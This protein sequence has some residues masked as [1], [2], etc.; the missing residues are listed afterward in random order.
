VDQGVFVDIAIGGTEGTDLGGAYVLPGFIDS[1]IHGFGPFDFE[2]P[3]CDYAAAAGALRHLGVTA[4]LPTVC[5]KEN[6]SYPLVNREAVL[7]FHLEGPFINPERLGGF[8]REQI[9][10]YSHSLAE[11]IFAS[12]HGQA[13]IMTAAPEMVSLPEMQALAESL[14]VRL[15][16]GHTQTDL[17]TARAAF[18][19]GFQAVTHFFNAM[20][21]HHHRSPGIWDEAML[22]DQVTLEVIADLHHVSAESLALLI[23]CKGARKL[24][25]V[26]DC[27]CA[28]G[29]GF[30]IKDG[31][32]YKNGVIYGSQSTMYDL[33][34]NLVSRLEVPLPLAVSMTSANIAKALGLPL[35]DIRRGYRADFLVMDEELHLKAIHTGMKMEYCL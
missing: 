2:D 8:S 15:S 34:V 23:R 25:A 1:H 31:L 22:N 13:R 12:F 4:F 5:P 30:E 21:G 29:S 10:P 20:P 9:L 28:N 3:G 26:T 17:I 24:I 7:G 33:F 11:E 16:A 32:A 6:S 19:G 14:H 35:G 27:V 18:T